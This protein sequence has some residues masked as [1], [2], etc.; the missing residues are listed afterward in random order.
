MSETDYGSNS[1]NS[2][3]LLEYEA[4]LLHLHW[5]EKASCLKLYLLKTTKN[6]IDSGLF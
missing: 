4:H 5:K 3:S 2:I 6:I 1:S